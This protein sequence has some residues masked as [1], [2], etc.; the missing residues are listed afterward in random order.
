MSGINAST[1]IPTIQL[2]SAASLS[3]EA[4]D[5]ASVATRATISAMPAA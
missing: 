1:T 5:S 2:M 4:A 3:Q